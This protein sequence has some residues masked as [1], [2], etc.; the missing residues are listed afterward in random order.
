M[1]LDSRMSSALLS[2]PIGAGDAPLG[3]AAACNSGAAPCSSCAPLS[4][5]MAMRAMAS[6]I[7]WMWAPTT[8]IL[9]PSSVS[10]RSARCRMNFRRSVM[11]F[12]VASAVERCSSNTSMNSGNV[13]VRSSSLPSATKIASTMSMIAKRSTSTT[14]SIRTT[15]RSWTMPRKSFFVIVTSVSSS[16]ARSLTKVHKLSLT[17]EMANSSCSVS[18]T[19]DTT[20]QST[21]INVFMTVSVARSTNK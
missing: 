3:A 12:T 4:W 1:P 5:A 9:C 18:A 2:V 16:S 17:Y 19:A 7:A 14:L 11:S 21:P 15:F 13:S 10:V 8:L 6:P 20:S